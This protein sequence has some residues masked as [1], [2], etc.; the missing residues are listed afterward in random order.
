[1]NNVTVTDII[2][3]IGSVA[4][5]IGVFLAWWQIRRNGDNARCA[6]E[7]ELSREYRKIVQKLPAGALL[8]GTPGAD[9]FK[10]ALGEFYRYIDFCNELIILRENGRISEETWENWR[11]GIQHNLARPAFA[12]AWKEIAS[13]ATGDFE[14]LRRLEG[15]EFDS[16]PYVDW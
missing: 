9:Q 4:T 12:K 13:K 11:M 14:E 8:G 5:A 16:D 2:I 7:G 6:F 3:A 10:A 15:E 1:M